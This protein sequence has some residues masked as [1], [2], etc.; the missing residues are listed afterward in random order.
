MAHELVDRA[1]QVGGL[2]DK[3]GCQTDGYMLEGSDGWYPTS[4]IRLVQD[5]GVDV[6][7]SESEILTTRH[8]S[9]PSVLYSYRVY[10]SFDL[11]YVMFDSKK[12]PHCI[13]NKMSA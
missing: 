7:V 5:Y 10:L 8:H 13:S 4:F 11:V 6:E 12:S 2:D 9:L 3:K 1:V